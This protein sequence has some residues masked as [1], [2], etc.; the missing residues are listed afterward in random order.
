MRG[1]DFWIR[2][3]ITDLFMVGLGSL[4]LARDLRNISETIDVKIIVVTPWQERKFPSG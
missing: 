3:A 1:E 2:C 4:D